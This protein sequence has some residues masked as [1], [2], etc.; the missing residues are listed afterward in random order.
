MPFSKSMKS[1]EDACRAALQNFTKEWHGER[2]GGGD[3]GTNVNIHLTPIRI[4]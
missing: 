1:Q 4:N 2:E 3:G